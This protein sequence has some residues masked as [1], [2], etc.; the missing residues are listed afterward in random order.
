MFELAKAVLAS[1]FVVV[2]RRCARV[3]VT[4]FSCKAALIGAAVNAYAGENKWAQ[5]MVPAN[6][7]APTFF[8]LTVKLILI[9]SIT[10]P[11]SAKKGHCWPS[12]V[13]NSSTS[14][15]D[16]VKRSSN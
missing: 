15:T 12:Y 9:L 11:L 8:K 16:D 5:N 3:T 1:V 7:A 4:D 14:V 2:T 10:A 13:L 6:K